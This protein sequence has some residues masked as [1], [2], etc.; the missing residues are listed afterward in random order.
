[1]RNTVARLKIGDW[2]ELGTAIASTVATDDGVTMKVSAN[3]SSREENDIC[4]HHHKDSH[5]EMIVLLRKTSKDCKWSLQALTSSSKAQ[6]ETPLF[7][8]DAK[9]SVH[10]LLGDIECVALGSVAVVCVFICSNMR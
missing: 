1:M 2:I 10:L 3:E 5:F 9:N 4:F 7:T 6:I 8:N